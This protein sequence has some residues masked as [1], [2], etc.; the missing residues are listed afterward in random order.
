[1]G[2]FGTDD[3]VKK[4]EKLLAKEEKHDEKS[5]KQ[6]MKDLAASQKAEGKA[7]KVSVELLPPSDEDPNADFFSHP[8]D[9]THE[10]TVKAHDKILANQHRM[11]EKVNAMVLERDKLA[12]EE[13]K[14]A[15]ASLPLLKIDNRTELTAVRGCL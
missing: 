4:E 14:L 7:A 11:Q 9:Q 6:A 13:R 5:V 12:A 8:D 2:L 10:H 15:E 1:M 3:P